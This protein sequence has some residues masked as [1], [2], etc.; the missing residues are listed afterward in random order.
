[1]LMLRLIS[2]S[3]LLPRPHPAK[4]L[5]VDSGSAHARHVAAG[6]TRR[7]AA[8]GPVEPGLQWRHVVH[9]AAR[10]RAA[11]PGVSAGK[12]FLERLRELLAGARRWRR[13]AMR[14]SRR[15]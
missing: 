5:C 10:C 4:A 2:H 15:R 7:A 11:A 8:R 13:T 1:M 14:A 3:Y 12:F 6:G 9:R